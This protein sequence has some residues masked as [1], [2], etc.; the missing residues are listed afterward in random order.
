MEHLTTLNSLPAIINHAHT[1]TQLRRK[2]KQCPRQE[3]GLKSRFAVHAVNYIRSTCLN[4][5]VE[6][7]RSHGCVLHKNSYGI[8]LARPV[9]TLRVC[10]VFCMLRSTA[11]LAATQRDRT[12]ETRDQRPTGLFRPPDRSARNT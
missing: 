4:A 6:P 2:S 3:S 12:S 8:H 7:R 10:Y 5:Q 9:Q 11:S 1:H